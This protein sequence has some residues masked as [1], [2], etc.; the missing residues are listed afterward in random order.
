MKT[1]IVICMLLGACVSADRPSA[2]YV[3]LLPLPA[4]KDVP[5]TLDQTVIDGA[6][7]WMPLGFDFGAEPSGLRE[8]DPPWH[9]GDSIEC[10]ISIGIVRDPLLLEKKGKTA[11]SNRATRIIWIDA[12]VIDTDALLIASAHEA[13]HILLNTS[14]HTQGGIMGGSDYVMHQ[15]DRDLACETVGLCVEAP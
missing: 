3:H 2:P 5:P 7:A 1:V 10:E 4:I 11:E 14:I 8:C 13:G 15:V 12:D 9:A 6:S